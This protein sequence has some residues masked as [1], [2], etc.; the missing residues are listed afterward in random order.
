M[1]VDRHRRHSPGLGLLVLGW[2]VGVTAPWNYVEL[3]QAAV[4]E[5]GC[6]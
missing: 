6:S 2:P 1:V 4:A 5:Q 3:A